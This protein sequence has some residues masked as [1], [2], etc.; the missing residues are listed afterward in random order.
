LVVGLL[1]V[2]IPFLPGA[3]WFG[4][5]PLPLPVLGGLV[6]ITLAYLAAS[7]AVKHWFFA[8]RRRG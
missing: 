8:R 6:A 2:A 4:F 1:A 5:V 3:D 7:E